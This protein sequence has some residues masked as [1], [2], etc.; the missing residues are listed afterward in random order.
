MTRLQLFSV[1]LYLSFI[2]H[3]LS[4]LECW[5]Q[6][7]FWFRPSRPLSMIDLC[8]D[9]YRGTDMKIIIYIYIWEVIISCFNARHWLIR[10][11][12]TRACSLFLF[13]SRLG[14]NCSSLLRVWRCC[15][16]V[17]S[18][19]M[20]NSLGTLNVILER[21]ITILCATVA[22][23]S[24]CGTVKVLGIIKHAHFAHFDLSHVITSPVGSTTCV[25]IPIVYDWVNLFKNLIISTHD[26][27]VIAVKLLKVVLMQISSRFVVYLFFEHPWEV[28]ALWN[29]RPY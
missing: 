29:C 24:E 15:Q 20:L 8:T 28:F 18:L 6:S 19:M 14:V 7:L 2:Y 9:W 11:N 26:I 10:I 23:L 4:L 21:S 3:V 13:S 5:L 16:K 25:L 22:V 1:F 27:L 12:S 17:I